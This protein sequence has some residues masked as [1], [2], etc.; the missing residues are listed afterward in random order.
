MFE[1][2]TLDEFIDVLDDMF[3]DGFADI[4][5]DDEGDCDECCGCCECCC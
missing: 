5:V 2:E 4:L 3:T 1:V